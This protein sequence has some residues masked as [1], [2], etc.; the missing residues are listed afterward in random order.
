MVGRVTDFISVGSFPVFN[1]ADSGITVGV[2]VLL[3][4]VWLKEREEKK[5]AAELSAKSGQTPA[6]DEQPKTEN[7]QTPVNSTA[8]GKQ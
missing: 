6:N 2:I 1:V 5:K 7:D 8:N 4:G 3:L